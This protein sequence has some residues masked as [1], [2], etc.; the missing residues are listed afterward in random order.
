MTLSDT[1]QGTEFPIGQKS[2]P[3]RRGL[4]AASVGV[5][6]V[7]VTAAAVAI[8]RDDGSSEATETAA[9]GP[10]VAPTTAEGKTLKYPVLRE[11]TTGWSCFP[12]WSVTP[13]EDPVCVDRNAKAWVDAYYA[14]KEPKLQA[15][16]ILYMLR[17]SGDF[18]RTDAMATEL[19][20]GQDWVND[21][22]HVTIVSPGKLDPNDY[23]SL[24][25]AA[26]WV[27]WAGSPYEHL[28]VPL[29]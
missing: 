4:V 3:R 2:G 20:P 1:Q 15:A 16:G 29:R 11:G 24:G 18:S 9:A 7:V 27:M 21:G 25:T 13:V 22:P 14:G 23:A 6:A 17:G 5:V 26:P 8:L 19:A 12:D 10:V 28:H